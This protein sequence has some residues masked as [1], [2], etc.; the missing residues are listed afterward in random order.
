MNNKFSFTVIMILALSANLLFAKDYLMRLANG[1]QINSNTFEFDAFIKNTSTNFIMDSYQCAFSFN[2]NIKN[3]GTLVFSYLNGSSQLNN[4]PTYGIG[5]SSID[6]A[7]E[8]SFASS[9][10]G[11][12]TI[13]TVEKKVGRFRIQNSKSFS[14]VTLDI[15][16]NFLGA[17]TT[18]VTKPKAVSFT[19]STNHEN[20]NSQNPVSDIVEIRILPTEYQLFQN[21]P[22]PFNPRTTIRYSIPFESN[23]KIS[24]YTMLGEFISTLIEK[25]EEAGNYSITWD[26]GNLAAGIY[27]YSI[28]AKDIKGAETYKAVK[29]LLLVK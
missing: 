19:D 5:I 7:D 22:N 14:D 18:I 16:W 8:L 23:V 9:M 20:L 13:T 24:V 3:G 10:D 28:E 1:V 12:D 17:V 4:I 11:V 2:E 6:G 26:A 29:K 25:V 15:K 27:I 21:Y